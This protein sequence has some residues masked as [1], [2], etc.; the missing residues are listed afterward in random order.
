MTMQKTGLLLLTAISL[1]V[2][3][4]GSKTES[5]APSPAPSAATKRYAMHGKVVSV[6][7]ADKSAKID[8]SEITGWMSAMMMDY[9]VRESADLAKLA[10]D[11][12]IDAT[13]FVDGDNFW[14]GEIKDAPVPAGSGK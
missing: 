8:A 13:V 12:M 7:A 10:A 1:A 6:N 5:A 4:C 9:P 2:A 3:G 11:K 14:I